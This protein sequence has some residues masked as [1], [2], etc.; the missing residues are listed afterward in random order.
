MFC[1]SSDFGNWVS[2]TFCHSLKNAQTP[3]TC[4]CYHFKLTCL[5]LL[6]TCPTPF[7]SPSY[8]ILNGKIELE[9]KSKLSNYYNWLGT[10]SRVVMGPTQWHTD[11][12]FNPRGWVKNSQVH[13]LC[14]ECI[15]H[16]KLLFVCTN[17]DKD[18]F[19]RKLS[20]EVLLDFL[21]MHLFG[22]AM[23]ICQSIHHFLFP[24]QPF[25]GMSWLS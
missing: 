10:C 17:N 23:F 5:F 18:N 8:T 21:W 9:W 1:L 11:H 16:R 12:R 2:H 4:P 20:R 25:T 6:C 14:K 22:P 7:L 24:T 13:L 3:R 15:V 19:C